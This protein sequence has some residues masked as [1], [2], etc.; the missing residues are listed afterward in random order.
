[1]GE[2]GKSLFT[3]QSSGLVR[4]VSV[5]NA[6]FFNTS[7]FIGGTLGG[8]YQIAVLAGVPVVV[9]G[10]ITNWSVVAFIVGALC[11]LLA[12]IFASLTSVMPRSGGDYVFSS[13]IVPK[14]GPFLGWLESW[15]LVFASIA[16]LQFE[17]VQTLRST[18]VEGRIIGIGTGTD[19]FNNASSWFTDGN[20]GDVTSWA[21]F[22]PAL[23]VFALVGWVVLQPTRTFHRI[24]TWLTILGIVGWALTAV[25]GL[26]FFDPSAFAANLPTYANG[27][28]VDQLTK[29]ASDAGLTSGFSFGPVD[30]TTW[31]LMLMAGVML[32]QFIG[33][34]YSAYISG[35]VRGNVKRGILIAVLGALVMAVL[36]NSIYAEALGRRLGMDAQTAWS[37]LWW[38]YIDPSKAGV[39]LPMNAPNYFQLMGAVA[40]PELWPIWALV[41]AASTL[42]PFLLMPV[43]VIFISRIALAWSLDRQVPEWLGEVSE[44]LRAPSN[45]IFA[46]LAIGVVF[47]I[48]WAF[49]VLKWIGLGSLAPSSDPA[50]DGKLNLAASA[51]FTI[52]ASSLSWIMP[53]I[54][55]LLARYTRKD[56]VAD[57]PYVR[58][59]PLMGAVWLAFTVVLYW[60]AGVG[61]IYNAISGGQEAL[62]YLNSS[63]VTFV[64]IIAVVGIVWY[65]IQSWRNRRAGVQTELMY[66]MLPPD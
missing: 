4:E 32:F 9:V 45:A 40:H 48:L 46:T 13:R 18:Q 37:G 66:R 7:A 30:G 14:I 27:I 61:P 54:N 36:M 41:G 49:P 16:L 44:R 11:V 31:P 64:G 23:I 24:V 19:F 10:V 26:L 57:A 60:F 50:L 58:W 25:F 28:T 17:T 35:E 42:F 56:L 47:L 52:L 55:A 65:L 8:A 63:G 39:S 43:Y 3:R 62:A 59:L 2:A 53:G 51:W 33:F 20:T 12:F 1:M 21:G 6:L 29:A 34:Q 5:T 22:I 15:G 38:G